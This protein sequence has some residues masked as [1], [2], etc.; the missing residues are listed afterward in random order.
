MMNRQQKKAMIQDLQKN[1]ET[2]QSSFLVNV[3]GLTVSD[4]QKV[5]KGVYEKGGT[6]KVAKNTLL[7]RA[8]ASKPEL[9]HLEP[10]FKDQIAVIF[11]SETPEIAKFIF[12]E[13]KANKKLEIV[14]GSLDYKALDKSQIEIL[15]Q[16]PSKDVLR[17]QVA[18][19]LQAPITSY[20][21]VLNKLILRLLWVLKEIEEKKQ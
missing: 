1:L 9:S 14:A 11:T 19:A 5:R 4:M 15:A 17:A 8:I 6:L 21:T 2:Y 13:S 10:H 3:K 7:K 16:L 12:Q 20:V 18:A